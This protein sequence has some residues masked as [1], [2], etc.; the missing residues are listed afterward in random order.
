MGEIT[1]TW[2]GGQDDVTGMMTSENLTE[3]EEEFA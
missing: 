1:V 3:L 2:C